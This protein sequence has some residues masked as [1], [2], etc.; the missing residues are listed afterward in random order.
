MT[1]G[2]SLQ[3]YLKIY[4]EKTGDNPM[5]PWGYRLLYLAERGF[6]IM[7]PDIEGKMMIVY[8]VCGDGKF[9]RDWAELEAAC[10]GFDCVG[11]ICTRAIEPYIRSFGWEILSKSEINGQRR[12]RCQDSIGRL[13]ICTYKCDGDPIPS[14]YGEPEEIE[15][16]NTAKELADLVWDN[17]NNDNKVS[18]FVRQIPLDGSEPTEIIINKNK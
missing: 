9:W 4:K 1:K 14:F 11:T 6:A 17:L 13:I 10:M 5:V 16:P 3:E 2:K 18:L 15:L 8:Q 12:Y 7:K